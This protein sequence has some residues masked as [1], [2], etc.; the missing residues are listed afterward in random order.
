MK[1]GSYCPHLEQLIGPR[2]GAGS[3]RLVFTDNVDRFRRVSGE[4]HYGDD[5]SES[6]LARL[7]IRKAGIDPLETEVVIDRIVYNKT[8]QEIM[9]ERK[10]GSISKVH[11]MY[12]AALSALKA[13]GFVGWGKKINQK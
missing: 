1:L 5:T 2:V 4:D 8:F 3:R 9:K 12:N 10:L 13:K 6:N 11:R 7:T